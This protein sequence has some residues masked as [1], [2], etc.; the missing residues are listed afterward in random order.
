MS[1]HKTPIDKNQAFKFNKPTSTNPLEY[2]RIKK[3]KEVIKKTKPLNK[4][5]KIYEYLF[6][7]KIENIKTT[8]N[9]NNNNNSQDIFNPK[10]MKYCTLI[11]PPPQILVTDSQIIVPNSVSSSHSSLNIASPA[12]QYIAQ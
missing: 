7:Q 1:K 2:Y 12:S 9:N 3:P 8:T 5:T 10:N 4:N 6:E 11:I